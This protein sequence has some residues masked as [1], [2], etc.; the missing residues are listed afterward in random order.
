MNDPVAELVQRGLSL[1]PEARERVVEGLL[2]SLNES[3]SSQ[4]DAAWEAEI[5]KRLAEY[6]R[7]SVQ[8][9]D[10]EAVFAKA[11]KLLEG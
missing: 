10:A 1:P 6:D 3:A 8:A 4:L 9:I 2:Q 11:R 7:G 5:E